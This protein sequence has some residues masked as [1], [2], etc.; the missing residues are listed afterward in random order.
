M[1]S[2]RVTVL[3]IRYPTLPVAELQRHTANVNAI[4]W[5]PHSA[6]H[7][8]S[9][10]DDSQALIWDLGMLGTMGQPPNGMAAAV[11]AGSSLDPILAYNAG[12]EVNQL[13]WSMAQPD[14][15]AVCFGTRTQ[16]LRV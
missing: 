1:D 15:L 4:C 13:Q 7:L 10:G 16:I 3:D 6:A 5:A 9:A 14:W 8:C 2:S 12:A 11:T